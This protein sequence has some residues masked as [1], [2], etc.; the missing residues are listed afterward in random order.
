MTEDEDRPVRH[1]SKATHSHEGEALYEAGA[2]LD[3]PAD[4]PIPE[5][6]VSLTRRVLNWRT[7]GS[8][9]LRDRPAGPRLPDAGRQPRGHLELIL[10]ANV[11]LPG[12]RVR[13]LLR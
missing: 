3:A 11:G 7:I 6:E 2:F 8:V 4:E 1:P 13:R 12:A 9:D 10:G 5:R